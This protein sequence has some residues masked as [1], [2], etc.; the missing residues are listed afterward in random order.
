MM[1]YTLI[2]GEWNVVKPRSQVW[3]LPES[4]WPAR[5]NGIFCAW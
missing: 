4:G 3:G 2:D 1:R 5:L